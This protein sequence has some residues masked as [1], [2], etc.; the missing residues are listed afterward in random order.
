MSQELSVVGKRLPRPDGAEKAT[1][2]AKYTVDIKLQGMLI[3]KVL[4]SPYPHAKILKID[5]SK[6]EK[7]PGVEAVITAEDV[8]KKLFNASIF[9]PELLPPQAKAILDQYILNDKARFVGDAIAAVAAINARTAEEALK[10]IEV[11]Y[12]ELAAVFDPIEAMKPE[13]P[14]IHDF[15]DGN[16][17]QHVPFPF[18]MGDVKKGFEEADYIIEDTFRTSKQKHFQLEPGACVASFD[19]N[20]RLTVWSPCQ[21]M[22]AAK[23]KIAW[24]FDIPQAMVKWLTPHIGGAF[25]SGGA[26]YIEPIC[27]ALAKKTGKPVKLELSR[28]QDT[29]ARGSRQPTIATQKIGVRKDGTITALH[30]RVIADAGAYI[31]LS[32]GATFFCMGWFLERY[33][34]F[35]LDGEGDVVYTNTSVAGPMR[36]YGNPE[37]M[38]SLE[39]LIDMA[40]EKIGMD[41]M[42]FRL[43]NIK[44][45]G[46]PSI[47]PNII[48]ENSA[49]DECIKVGA[50]RID[51]KEKRNRIKECIKRQGLGMACSSHVSC[52]Q[53]GI[54][55]HSNA[56]ININADG[57]V[58]V[59]VSPC[60]MGQGIL[61][62]LAQIAAEELG[63]RYE[64]IKIVAGDTDATLFD[65]GSHASRSVY[66]IGNAVIGAAREAKG[67]LLE[68]AAKT[69]GVSADELAI[70]DRLIYLR[71]A[72]E[73][74]ISVAEVAKAAI[75]N[76]EG[77]CLNISGK[78]S[79]SPP[80]SPP[81]NAAFA[82]V[83]VDTETGE[84]K[85]LKLVIAA[86]CG[87]A[88]NPM[89]VE[90]QYEGG[91]IQGLG[92]ALTEDFVVD[93]NTG[94]TL[95][96]N[97]NTYKIPRTPDM[98]EIEVILVEQ[99]VHSGP[100]GA[101]GVG[102][103]AMICIAP[104]IA[105]AIYD[106]VGIRVKEL[107]ITPERVLN[108]LQAK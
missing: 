41:P 13:A 77:Q 38:F 21:L 46:E 108:A 40:A 64:D 51:W 73:K 47:P 52:A 2:T 67:Q 1:G 69:L 63:L 12:E 4:R 79:F 78:C 17:A 5:K 43:K 11:E 103:L 105:N 88:I 82:E 26:V 8:P 39:Q 85:V 42:E 75:Y 29:V 25:G 22:H 97:F 10:L 94:T 23:R 37:A 102:E 18:P 57:S 81:F 84:V 98:P 54:L 60:E 95:T 107:P 93:M 32:G 27:I 7:L 33:R 14:R 86:D 61:G 92:F 56:F 35:N 48:I 15:A 87:R 71:K 3:G 99:P 72:P 6:A 76:F 34:C 58:I 31:T 50:E 19:A 100:F 96:D 104:A 28:E 65:I 36:G 44:G 62:P 90:G 70:K 55:E 106:A 89:N 49:L 66:V 74:G 101:K 30:T 45:S 80:Q 24:L 91:A 20:R 59:S 83:E 53:S 16:I 9:I 68:R